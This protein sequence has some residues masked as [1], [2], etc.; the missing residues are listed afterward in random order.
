ME[1]LAFHRAL[2]LQHSLLAGLARN[3]VG[4]FRVGQAA[5]IVLVALAKI[6]LIVAVASCL[7]T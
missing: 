2:F 7:P 1:L 6:R 5:F 3:K 4:C